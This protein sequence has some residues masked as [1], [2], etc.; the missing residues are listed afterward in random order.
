MFS[1]WQERQKLSELAASIEMYQEKQMMSEL[2]ASI[3]MHRRKADDVRTISE[4][5]HAP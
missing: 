2:A 1:L 4:Y 5:R 3:E